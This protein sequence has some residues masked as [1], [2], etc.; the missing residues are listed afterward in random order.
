MRMKAVD[1][2]VLRGRKWTTVSSSA[3]VPGDVVSVTAGRSAPADCL[4]LSGSLHVDEAILTGALQHTP[5]CGGVCAGRVS[6]STCYGTVHAS[7]RVRTPPAL[8]VCACAALPL[9]GLSAMTPV[10][11]RRACAGESVPLLKEGLDQRGEEC[12]AEPLSL[13]LPEHRSGVVFGGT[14]VVQAGNARAVRDVSRAPDGGCPAVV[15]RT[16]FDTTQ[17][18]AAPRSTRRNA[19]VH[20]AP[21]RQPSRRAACVVVATASAADFP[22]MCRASWCG[23]SCLPATA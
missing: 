10:P 9:R 7:G 16:G 12:S 23:G 14:T 2:A 11:P 20:A 19:A 22:G 18:R 3:L 8:R 1:V 21:L 17:A 13:E 5:R 15:L 4:V 6:A